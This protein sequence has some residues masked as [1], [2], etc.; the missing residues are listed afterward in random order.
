MYPVHSSIVLDLIKVNSAQILC[1]VIE[2][3]SLILLSRMDI[4]NGHVQTVVDTVSMTD[5]I[6]TI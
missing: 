3:G 2:T 5:C 1:G 6:K 4:S